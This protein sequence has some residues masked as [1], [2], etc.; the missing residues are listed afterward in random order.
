MHSEENKCYLLNVKVIKRDQ[1]IKTIK[2]DID[3]SPKLLTPD[4][5]N[6]LYLSLQK[7]A[8]A[9]EAVKQAHIENI[10]SRATYA[11]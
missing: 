4:E 11:E 6:Q 3:D 7:Y 1:L 10:K 9:D 8:N 2:Q 5:V